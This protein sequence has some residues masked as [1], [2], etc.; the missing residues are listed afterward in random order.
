V[1]RLR[2][3][4]DG[5]S[6][7]RCGSLACTFSLALSSLSS[8]DISFEYNASWGGQMC[9]LMGLMRE[10]VRLKVAAHSTFERLSVF[11]ILSQ[12]GEQR[13]ICNTACFLN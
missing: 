12:S 10:D 7:L 3:S 4:H 2:K 13:I 6:S 5:K 11:L 8:S 9:S 1:R